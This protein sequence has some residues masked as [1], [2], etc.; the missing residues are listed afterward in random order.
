M[1]HYIYNLLSH[2]YM[3]PSEAYLE[4]VKPKEP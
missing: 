4:V 1:N 3:Y 2:K